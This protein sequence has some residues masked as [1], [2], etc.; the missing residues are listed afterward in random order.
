[1]FA[2]N[3]PYAHIVPYFQPIFSSHTA[4]PFG[5]EVL[6]RLVQNGNPISLGPFF[7]DPERS[8]EVKLKM[9]FHIREIAIRRFA[10]AGCPGKLFLNIHPEWADLMDANTPL[11]SLLTLAKIQCTA[12][13]HCYGNYRRSL[14]YHGLYGL[15]SG[16]VQK[17]RMHGCC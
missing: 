12:I 6:G 16:C 14:A 7:E 1:M 13:Q 10:E 4:I 3:I 17:G 11:H 9:D 8:E 5:Y 15:G 2:N